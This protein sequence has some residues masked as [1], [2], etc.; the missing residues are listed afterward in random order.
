MRKNVGSVKGKIVG[1]AFAVLA[2]AFLIFLVI[3]GKEKEE[4]PT[5]VQDNWQE[6]LFDQSL[7]GG[8]AGVYLPPGRPE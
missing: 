4:A 3:G 7:P 5:P 8:D 2:L 6:A 1:I